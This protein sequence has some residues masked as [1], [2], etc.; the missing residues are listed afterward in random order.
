M[1][2]VKH[3]QMLEV[4]KNEEPQTMTPAGAERRKKLL[5]STSGHR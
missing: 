4:Y 1:E 5:S 2:N 3:L